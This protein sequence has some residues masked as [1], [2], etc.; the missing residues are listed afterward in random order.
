MIWETQHIKRIL[1]DL[2]L[3]VTDTPFYGV[4]TPY[5]T[6]GLDW[7][8]DVGLD[9]IQLMHLSVAA[10]SFFSLFEMD[11][12]P[13]LLSYSSVDEW[14]SEILSAKKEVNNSISFTSSG[15]TGNTK[16]VKHTMQFLDREINFLST[17]FNDATQIIPYIPSYTIYGFLF[18]VGLQQKLKIPVLYPSEINLQNLPSKALIVATPFHW[19]VILVPS[20]SVLNCYGVSSGAPLFDSLFKDIINKN[21]I[22]TELYGSTET[23]GVAFRKSFLQGFTL[24]P[25][26]KFTT[27][28]NN[29]EIE[30]QDTQ[31]TYMLMDHIGINGANTLNIL[32]RKDKKIKIAGKLADLD[33]IQNIIE[34]FPA[35]QNCN[36]SAKRIE[37][38]VTIH[39]YLGLHVDNKANREAV[40][41][42]IRSSLKPHEIPKRVTFGSIAAD[43]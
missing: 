21:V 24:F 35:V 27:T 33:Y 5:D 37:N 19:Q 42:Q 10:G 17:L 36:L 11:Q 26:W 34:Q 4:N 18:T 6:T 30:D 13:Y 22:L 31:L 32:G 25:Y 43:V 39:A 7:K 41:K 2:A 23:A 20:P 9:S 40:M 1:L 14:V 12:P 29:S 38:K 3:K 16:V 28:P 8:N 15:T